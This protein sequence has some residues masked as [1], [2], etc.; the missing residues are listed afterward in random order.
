MGAPANNDTGLT[1]G[2]KVQA[3]S[4]CLS[5]N[6]FETNRHSSALL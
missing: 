3:S 6:I 4:R 5:A 1:F 2:T